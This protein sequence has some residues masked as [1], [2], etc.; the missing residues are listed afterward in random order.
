MPTSSEIARLSFSF[1]PSAKA[2]KYPSSKPIPLC[3][4]TATKT[5]S[6]ELATFPA[7]AD[8][9]AAT[10]IRIATTEI[11]GTTDTLFAT[12]P[13]KKRWISNPRTIG[14]MMTWTIDLNIDSA[15]TGNHCPA[16]NSNNKGVTS[17]AS[18]VEREVIATDNARF[19][20]AK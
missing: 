17:G 6:P 15:S 9:T 10:M 2:I 5:I 18:N 4:N 13:G 20:F 8:V 7:L 11:I 12:A 14:M 1:K 3:K 19:P 16:N